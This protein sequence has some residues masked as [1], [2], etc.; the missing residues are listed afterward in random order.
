[1]N[2]DET[3]E[4]VESSGNIFADLGLPNPEER[5]AKAELA[6]EIR[7][8]I[9][10]RAL[11]QAQAGALLGIAQ[12]NVSD[13]MRGKLA[14][15]SVEKMLAFLTALGRDIRIV[16][17]E[18]DVPEEPGEISVAI[19]PRAGRVRSVS[20]RSSAGTPRGLMVAGSGDERHRRRPD[21]PRRSCVT[22]GI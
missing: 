2:T 7:R 22:W 13:L 8:I 21:P 18:A 6:R 15:F 11:T 12:P 3:I 14:R 10:E 4:F 1:M 9:A 16:V 17:T 5:L 19:R 20:A